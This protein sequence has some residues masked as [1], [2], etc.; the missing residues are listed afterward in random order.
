MNKI[1]TTIV[2]L[3]TVA[4]NSYAQDK[5][6]TN[7]ELAKSDAQDIATVLKL[8]ENNQQDFYRLFLMK[9]EVLNNPDLTIERKKEMVRIVGLKIEAS[10]DGNQLNELKKSKYYSKITGEEFLNILKK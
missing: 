2:L 8:S 10:I 4:F 3:L 9:Q 1:I 6:G 5:K 7:Q